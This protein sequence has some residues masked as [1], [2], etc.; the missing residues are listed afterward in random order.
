MSEPSEAEIEDA[1]RTAFQKSRPG[2]LVELE[3]L[4]PSEQ[5]P[6]WNIG[7]WHAHE[8]SQLR[9]EVERL[10]E[11]LRQ[12]SEGFWHLEPVAAQYRAVE[13]AR[14]ALKPLMDQHN[15]NRPA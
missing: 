12:I 3:A 8:T 15:E 7:K 2:T 6:F 11:A 5:E 14:E 13:I 1:A 10:R 9:A 4:L